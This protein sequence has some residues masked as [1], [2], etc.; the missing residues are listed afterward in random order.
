MASDS[1]PLCLT[2]LAS[3]LLECRNGDG[4]L[5]RKSAEYPA[6]STSPVYRAHSVAGST[7]LGPRRPT[8]GG[9]ARWQGCTLALS[10]QRQ[11]FSF[12]KPGQ[13]RSLT[14]KVPE[15]SERPIKLLHLL[16]EGRQLVAHKLDLRS[17]IS[18]DRFRI[19]V[20]FP[21][22][23]SNPIRASALSATAS[24]SCQ[25]RIEIGNGKLSALV[26]C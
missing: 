7:S 5:R 4:R 3:N 13:G 10:L 26:S 9:F 21:I 22:L 12:L 2:T 8:P 23:S 17:D 20:A 1:V 18:V 15:F 16:L 6:G 14:L 24:I 25:P 19:S 11:Q